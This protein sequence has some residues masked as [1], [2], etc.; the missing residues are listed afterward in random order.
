M[1]TSGLQA[2]RQKGMTLIEILLVIAILGIVAS[3]AVPTISAAKLK[4]LDMASMELAHAIRFARSEAIRTNQAHGIHLDSADTRLR[5]YVYTTSPEYTVYHPIN[6]NLYQI[7]F[8]AVSNPVSIGSKSIKFAGTSLNFQS[9]IFFEAGT[10]V[11]GSS[12]VGANKMLETA[13]F[14]LQYHGH[15]RT[16]S[17]LPMSGK[18][19]VQ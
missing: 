5:V 15:E 16:V 2:L 17:L 6:K 8:D 3:V 12:G 10:G 11:P 9:Y 4:Q 19:T 1:E 13:D 7:D 14:V 18:V